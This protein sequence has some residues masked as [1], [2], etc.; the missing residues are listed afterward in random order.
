MPE[1]KNIWPKHIAVDKRIVQILSGSTYT[2]FPSAI[3]E[4]IINSYDADAEVVVVDIDLNKEIIT[5]RDDGKGMSEEDFSFYLRIAGKTRKKDENITKGR[6]Q[7]VGQFG[8]GFL[9]VLPFCEK[10]LIE[11]KKKGTGEIVKATITSSEYFKNDFKEIDVEE[12]PIYGGISVDNSL[13]NEQYTRIRLVG[14]SALTKSFFEGKYSIKSRRNTIYNFSPIE[15]LK[16]E[17]AEYLPIE[18]DESTEIG[19]KINYVFKNSKA[20]PFKVYVNQERLFRKVH[21]KSILEI[22][23]KEEK[24]G[25]IKFKYALL[26]DYEPIS[27]KEGRHLM[28]RNLNV[29]VGERT[30]L[31]IG[32]EG[33]VYARLAHLTGEVNVTE[34]LN[35]L[36]SVSR[37]K[38]NFSPDYE[39]L[40]D[41]LRQRLSFWA[42][43]LDT[44]QTQEKLVS[45]LED[46]SKVTSIASLKTERLKQEINTL[47][48]KG[49]EITTG[50]QFGES[51]FARVDK[52]DKKIFLPK[53]LTDYYKV[54]TVTGKDYKLVTKKWNPDDDFPAVQFEKDKTLVNEQYPLFY[55]KNQFDTFL[56]LHILFLEYY[57]QGNISYKVYKKFLNDILSTFQK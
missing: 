16:W 44:L 37:D 20:L 41:F 24:I 43:E 10:Y 14:F 50:E 4:L 7:I 13:W 2:N 38:F 54:I 3:R 31:G 46:K 36:I 17:L 22:S 48:N 11:T 51:Q 42:S 1:Q 56:K 35:D 19:K 49:F 33:R 9:S 45:Q 32:L 53:S 15:L 28:L 57:V 30:T 40:K 6:R 12:I 29:G 27:P 55:A 18:Y 21:A 39:K 47:K 5:I 25:T 34:G 23:E 8:V 26:T 52:A